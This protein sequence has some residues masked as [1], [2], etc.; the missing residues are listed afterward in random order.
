MNGSLDLVKTLVEGAL[1]SA[2]IPDNTGE[3]CKIL[4]C[5]DSI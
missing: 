3:N 1:N 4:D 2:Q 5:L